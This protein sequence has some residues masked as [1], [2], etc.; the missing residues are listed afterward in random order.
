VDGSQRAKGVG[1]ELLSATE[2][3][4]LQNRCDAI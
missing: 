2:K 1:R 3:L 4:A